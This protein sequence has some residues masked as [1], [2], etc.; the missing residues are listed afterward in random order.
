MWHHRLVAQTLC[1]AHEVR[2]AIAGARRALRHC[3]PVDWQTGL[4]QMNRQALENPQIYAKLIQQPG[5]NWLPLGARPPKVGQMISLSNPPSRVVVAGNKR[6]NV[7]PIVVGW[8]MYINDADQLP[9][10]CN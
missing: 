5:Q 4:C 2:R 6:G 1:L 10:Y 3:L 7:S 9:I 8:G